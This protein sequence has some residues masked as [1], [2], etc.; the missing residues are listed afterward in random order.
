M[1]VVVSVVVVVVVG[2]EVNPPRSRSPRCTL[3]H[4][5][6]AGE[7]VFGEHHAG[8]AGQKYLGGLMYCL[9]RARANWGQQQRFTQNES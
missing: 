5:G 6:D 1:V 2:R 4:T 8:R 9:H 7:K 3:V